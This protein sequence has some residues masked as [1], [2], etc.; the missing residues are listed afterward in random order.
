MAGL[1]RHL[2]GRY[3]ANAERIQ[4][5]QRT[6]AGFGALCETHAEVSET[7]QRLEEQQGDPGDAVALAAARRRRA[8][9][10]EE[11]MALV[12]SNVRV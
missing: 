2:L 6:H 9:L 10:E 8:A 7:I 4:K 1:L 12:S 3:P 11:L 5:L